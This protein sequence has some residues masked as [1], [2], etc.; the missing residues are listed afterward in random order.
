MNY[1]SGDF[2]ALLKQAVELADWKG[3]AA[4]KRESQKRGKLRGLGI[5]SLSWK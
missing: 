1:D 4:R 3:F 2:P 5:G